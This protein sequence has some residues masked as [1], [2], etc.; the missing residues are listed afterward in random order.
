MNVGQ[1]PGDDD[2]VKSSSR[3][4]HRTSLKKA[5][6]SRVSKEKQRRDALARQHNARRDFADHARRI[7][8]QAS[9]EEESES[10]TKRGRGEE[11]VDDDEGEEGKEEKKRMKRTTTK[12][13]DGGKDD[14][15]DVKKTERGELQLPEYMTDVPTDLGENWLCQPKPRGKRCAVIAA[16]GRTSAFDARGKRITLENKKK[17][18]QS[19]IPG[20]SFQ[21]RGNSETFCILDCVYGGGER[22]RVGDAAVAGDDDAMEEDG[23]NANDDN[24]GGYFVVLDVM[25]WNG[26]ETYGCDVEFRSFW[27]QSKFAS[28]IDSCAV[29]RDGHEYPMFP[30]PIFS[31]AT[32]NELRMCYEGARMKSFGGYVFA[33]DGLIFRDKR[34]SYTPGESTPLALLYKD[35]ALC[36]SCGEGTFRREVLERGCF[37]KVK[38]DGSG[39]DLCAI[40][41]NTVLVSAGGGNQLNPNVAVRCEWEGDKLVPRGNCER[42]GTRPDAFSK[43]QFYIACKTNNPLTMDEIASS[44]CK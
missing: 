22:R 16:R 21:T 28:E 3:Q 30:A 2:D 32:V 25:A 24:G 19:A 13:G 35:E 40:D 6:S 27:L 39:G 17:Y 41:D 20:G 5:Y 12:T 8:V 43:I 38:R 31:C 9:K 4:N 18:F 14:D 15:V 36:E 33:C 1:P 23:G 42:K 26:A 37:L 11:Y 7:V 10:K 44:V 34:A 29:S